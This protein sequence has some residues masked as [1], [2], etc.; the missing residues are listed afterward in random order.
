[1]LLAWESPSDG[2]DHKERQSGDN[3]WK[4]LHERDVCVAGSAGI[5]PKPPATTKE[6]PRKT[7][8]ICFCLKQEHKLQNDLVSEPFLSV[9]Q[10]VP[11]C[12]KSGLS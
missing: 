12:K 1:M 10:L 3:A 4:I 6:S 11:R 2:V 7:W 8:P 9:F 5:Y